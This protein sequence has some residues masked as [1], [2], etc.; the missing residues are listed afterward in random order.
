VLA[1]NRAGLV[2]V[3]MHAAHERVLYESF[4]L[5][6]AAGA[7]PRSACWSDASM[8]EH[9]ID[10]LPGSRRRLLPLRLRDRPLS[11]TQLAVRAVPAML[12]GPTCQRSCVKSCAI[13]PASVVRTI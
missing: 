9:E 1:Q 7:R 6:H 8:R 12:A 4:K 13:W 11:P 5:Q 10:A 2:L 3:D